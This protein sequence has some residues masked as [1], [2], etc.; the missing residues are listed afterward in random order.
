[1]VLEDPVIGPHPQIYKDNVKSVLT[2]M[3][4]GKTS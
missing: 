3:K 1:M 4:K 2:K